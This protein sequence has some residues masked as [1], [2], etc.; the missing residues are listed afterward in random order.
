MSFEVCN[1]VI[2]VD[3]ELKESEELDLRGCDKGL[4]EMQISPK[5]SS[6]ADFGA[7]SLRFVFKKYFFN[8][9]HTGKI[10]VFCKNSFSKRDFEVVLAELRA[11]VFDPSIVS[12]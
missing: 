8:V 5:Q 10:Q 2:K 4:R 3:L 11:K 12:F 9:F 6:E 1:I 7:I